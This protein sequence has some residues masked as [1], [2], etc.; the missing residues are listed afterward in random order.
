MIDRIK[1]LPHWCITDK[2][3]AF[4][5]T[6]SVTVIEQ[7]ARLY[8]AMRTLQEDYNKYV[9]EVN[10]VI[11]EFINT[12][13]ADQ[14][15][16]ENKITTIVHNYIEMLDEKIKIQ[17]KEIE[18]F[19][20]YMKNNIESTANGLIKEM[21]AS[22]EIDHD[23]Y[24]NSIAEMK[25]SNLLI[26]G[27]VVQT[28][29]Y[30]FANDGG[31]GMYKIRAKQDTD[32]EDNG[33]IH[34]IGNDL[35]AELIIKNNSVT[36]NQ[37]GA[38][39]DFEHDDTQA[40]Q[41]A[42][43]FAFS[44]AGDVYTNGPIV[45]GGNYYMKGQV[46]INTPNQFTPW[47]IELQA[48]KGEYDGYLFDIKGNTGCCELA[49]G[50]IDNSL[51]GCVQCI[52]DTQGNTW[53]G[54]SK[55]KARVMR[56]NTNYDCIHFETDTSTLASWINEIEIDVLRFVNGRYG[57]YAKGCHNLVFNHNDFEYAGCCLEECNGALFIGAHMS[58]KV[59]SDYVL[60]TIGSCNNLLIVGGSNGTMS[61]EGKHSDVPPFNLSNETNGGVISYQSGY[62]MQKEHISSSPFINITNGK[63]IRVETN[64]MRFA[65]DPIYDTRELTSLECPKTINA[66]ND[67]TD[68]ILDKDIYGGFGKINEFIIITN[69]T[70]LNVKIGNRG[71]NDE[72]LITMRT[73]DTALYKPYKFTWLRDGKWM[74]EQMEVENIDG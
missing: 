52:S 66:S 2:H 35:V 41:K 49:I 11:E 30:Y 43:D 38:Y 17:D 31:A 12:S 3:P 54:T 8:A 1:L 15:E 26:A 47:K 67:T 13:N 59:S 21:L 20:L 69:N 62:N 29:G 24:F 45:K 33:S 42:I 72:S 5:D 23:T 64:L 55:I 28:L 48:I 22:G 18:E 4:Y 50:S 16:F 56:A 51:G 39:G 19:G 70:S 61:F 60:K 32:I 9:D 40:I 36:P 57:V 27:D 53:F 25:T 73:F 46:V 34:F 7:T 14:E 37:F 63:L 65:N 58:D 10:K 6:E 74:M 71:D 68:I 44:K